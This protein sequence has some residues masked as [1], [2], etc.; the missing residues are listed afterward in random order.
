MEDSVVSGVC[1]AIE[2]A[3]HHAEEIKA[4]LTAPFAAAIA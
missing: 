4:Q 1:L 2:N 3:Y